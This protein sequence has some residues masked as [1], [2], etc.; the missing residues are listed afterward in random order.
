M[1]IVDVEATPLAIPLAR[2]FH[3]SGGVQSGINLVL[4]T[5]HTDEGVAGHGEAFAEDPEAVASFGRRIGQQI[6]GHSP[7]DMEAILHSVWNVGRWRFWP[8]FTQ[9]VFA[10]IEVACWDALGRFHGV[11]SRTFFG[12]AVRREVDFFAFVQGATAE[13]LGAHAAELRD[14][15]YA[16][17]YLKIGRPEQDDEASVAAVREAIG[18]DAPL[19]VDPNEAWDP[20]TAVERIRRLERYGLD[21]VEQP[22]PAGNLRG[23]RDVRRRV[24]TRIAADQS[25]FTTAELLAVLDA[26][27]ADV[28]V[29]SSHDAGG[30]WT[31]KQ[32]S[33]IAA[34]HG[35]VVNRHSFMESE[36]SVYANLQVL[37]GIPNLTTGNQM[38]CQLLGER[39]V[40]GPGLRIDGG[41]LAVP[42]GPGHGF[43]LDEEAV[44]RAH[45][46]WA[47][48]GPYRSGLVGTAEVR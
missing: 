11:P 46:R 2:E 47:T 40:T 19:R 26:E 13:E 41:R 1:R 17:F 48:Q 44:A 20:G 42:D 30:L 22:V 39:L 32:Q 15:G 8:H 34:A 33:A 4:F 36:I 18:P 43:T 28:I 9:M 12:G 25:V 38:M 5:V 10:G 3:W 21:W 14:H 16:V 29:Q 31:L 27:A 37:A 6:A 45:E 23:L 7:G 24:D 35:V